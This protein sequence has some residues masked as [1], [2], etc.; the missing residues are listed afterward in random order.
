ML[1]KESCH[2]LPIVSHRLCTWF[3]LG[4][5]WSWLEM[6]D[7]TY[8]SG[9]LR[10]PAKQPWRIWV[11]KLSSRQNG[12]HFA[13]NIFDHI[14]LNK[15]CCV[16]IHFSLKIFPKGS[17]DSNPSLVQIMAWRWIFRAKS[18][19]EPMIAYLLR[20]ICITQP[21]WVNEPYEFTKWWLFIH[22]KTK[23]NQIV[24]QM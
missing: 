11:N 22:N 7:L 15:N 10:I 17:I 14:F 20:H 4:H 19:S 18:L 13:V 1:L 8:S 21:Q 3:D 5:I 2:C 16:L 12:W 6:T 24:I 9:L 23:H